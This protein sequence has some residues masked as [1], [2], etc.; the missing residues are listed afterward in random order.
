MLLPTRGISSERALITLGADALSL[1]HS[2]TSISGLWE[3]FNAAR[4]KSSST[5]RVTFD[6]FSLALASLFA[7]GSVELTEEGY[8]RRVDVS[9]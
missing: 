7:I 6:W 1:L 8:L 3:R 9:H 4:T 5:E 2:P